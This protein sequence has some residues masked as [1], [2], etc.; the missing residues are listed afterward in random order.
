MKIKIGV[1]AILISLILTGCATSKP[2]NKSPEE[3]IR[4]NYMEDIINNY[5]EYSEIYTEYSKFRIAGNVSEKYEKFLERYKKEKTKEE[6][7][8][9]AD[10]GD[11]FILLQIAIEE[12]KQRLEQEFVTLVTNYL[13]A[14]KLQAKDTEY[15]FSPE[16]KNQNP[17]GK[18][19][20][21]LEQ[22]NIKIEKI[23]F[24]EVFE[25][26]DYSIYPAKCSYRY[27]LQGTVKGKPFTKEMFQDF[28]LGFDWQDK[29]NIFNIIE[30]IRDKK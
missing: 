10:N 17:E 13:K 7:G 25:E 4:V 8:K 30:Y 14:T 20:E 28:Y 18:V 24:P 23:I 19:L 16:F 9:F 26:V 27:V 22:E 11:K 29:K 5:E 1:F 6:I 21:Y 2:F 15:A 12:D 3:E